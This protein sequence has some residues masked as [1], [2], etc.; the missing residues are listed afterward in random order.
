MEKTPTGDQLQTAIDWFVRGEKPENRAFTRAVEIDY[1]RACLAEERTAFFR[2]GLL[3]SA[4]FFLV[5]VGLNLALLYHWY[6]YGEISFIATQAKQAPVVA[7]TENQEPKSSP[8]SDET[9]FPEKWSPDAGLPD[10]GL[11]ADKSLPDRSS[12]DRSLSDQ[13]RPPDSQ[14]PPDQAVDSAPTKKGVKTATPPPDEVW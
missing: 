10:R 7:R 1:D 6:Y 14:Q 12:S 8:D 13:L 4:F 11:A 9:A 2:R 5:A 3:C